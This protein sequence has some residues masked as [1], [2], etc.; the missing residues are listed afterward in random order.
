MKR[1]DKV[2]WAEAHCRLESWKAK[3]HQALELY[4]LL[5]SMRGICIRSRHIGGQEVVDVLTEGTVNCSTLPAELL[6]R[7]EP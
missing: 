5:R 7:V 4:D 1:G 2:R 3:P 6:E